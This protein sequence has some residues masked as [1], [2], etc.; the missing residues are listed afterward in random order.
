VELLAPYWKAVL[1]FITPAA[2]IIISSV[3]DASAGGQ[4][5]TASEWITAACTAIVTAG[6]VYTIK[7]RPLPEKPD[8]A[9]PGI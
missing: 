5:I 4:D 8:P 7:N 6:G 2:L 9:N 1:G 3:T